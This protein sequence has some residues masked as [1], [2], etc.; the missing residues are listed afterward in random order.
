M[1]EF[2]W[3]RGVKLCREAEEMEAQL[4]WFDTIAPIELDVLISKKG[5]MWEAL[6]DDDHVDFAD[7]EI[8]NAVCKAAVATLRKQLF[9][10]REELQELLLAKPGRH[11]K[12]E[13]D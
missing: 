9:D 1:T 7:L 8:V 5:I 11:G 12:V 3:E 13:D 4:E 6:C 2:N 10:E